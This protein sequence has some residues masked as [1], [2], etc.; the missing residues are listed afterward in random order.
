VVLA[1]LAMAYTGWLWLDPAVSL[2]IVVVIAVGTWGLLRESLDLALDAVP[3]RIDPEKVETYLTSLPG[4]EAV[5]DLHIW[6]MST[7]EAALTV[8][9]VKPDASIDD[10]LLALINKDLHAMF[11]IDHVTVQFEL[12]D[13]DHPCGQAPNSAV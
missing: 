6:G 11:G 13:E 3:V 12:G 2:A 7:T 5:H 4:V 8:H 10:A 1:A 9:L